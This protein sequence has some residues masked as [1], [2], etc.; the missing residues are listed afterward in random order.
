MSVVRPKKNGVCAA[1]DGE[2]VE[3][4]NLDEQDGS[5]AGQRETKTLWGTQYGRRKMRCASMSAHTYRFVVGA[6]IVFEGEV[7]KCH[8]RRRRTAAR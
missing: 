5:E 6:D 4:G 1:E 7:K 2:I 8:T 3:V